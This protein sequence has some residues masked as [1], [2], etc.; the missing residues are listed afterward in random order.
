MP[1]LIERTRALLDERIVAALRIRKRGMRTQLVLTDNSLYHTRTRTGTL[2]H[3][4]NVPAAQRVT[5]R[6]RAKP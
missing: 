4:A 5:Q 6:L 3:R 1:Y 2:M